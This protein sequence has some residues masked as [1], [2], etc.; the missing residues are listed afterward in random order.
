MKSDNIEFVP[1]E[2]TMEFWK[3][4]LEAKGYKPKGARMDSMTRCQERI[5]DHD[6]SS[7][8][9]EIYAPK[10]MITISPDFLLALG[11]YK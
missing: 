9:E 5:M 11:C 1:E 4:E 10:K 7:K 2:V 3:L 8:K 6:V